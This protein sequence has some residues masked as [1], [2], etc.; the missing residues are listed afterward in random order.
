MFK[1]EDELKGIVYK[2]FDVMGTG[3]NGHDANETVGKRPVYPS[4]YNRAEEGWITPYEFK[5]NEIYG[6]D[7]N[8]TL[9]TFNLS[10]TLQYLINYNCVKINTNTPNT[11]YL[12]ENRNSNIQTS[13]IFYDN[14]LYAINKVEFN[15]GLI[16]WK[17]E[18]NFI[19]IVN[20]SNSL[21]NVFRITNSNSDLT[22]TD[23]SFNTPPNTT[24][25]KK[26]YNIG[27]HLP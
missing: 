17:I 1:K 8:I 22:T 15:G 23:F 2:Y 24:G 7:Y 10:N 20:I 5:Y 4:C 11:Y 14:G 6:Q 27:I 3:Y 21:N 13:N 9:N 18:N 19:N 25:D 26:Q 16:I 12:I